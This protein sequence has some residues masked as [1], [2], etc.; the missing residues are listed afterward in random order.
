MVFACAWDDPESRGVCNHFFPDSESLPV[1]K[2]LEARGLMRLIA[3]PSELYGGAPVY[4]VTEAGKDAL[5]PFPATKR[6]KRK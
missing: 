6:G 5:G 1:C 2:A 4:S 3:A